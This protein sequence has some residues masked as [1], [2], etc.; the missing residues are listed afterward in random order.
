MLNLSLKFEDNEKEIKKS[1]CIYISDDCWEKLKSTANYYSI[2]IS[3]LIE[4]ISENIVIEKL[5]KDKSD[6]NNI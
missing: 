2:S 6:G 3:K 4:K 1:R 5:N